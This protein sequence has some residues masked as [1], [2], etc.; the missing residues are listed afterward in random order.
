[1][2]FLQPLVSFFSRGFPL[3]LVCFRG[4]SGPV[5]RFRSGGQEGHGPPGILPPAGR[6]GGL[7]L[8]VSPRA[9]DSGGLHTSV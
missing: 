2:P 7:A 9:A 8:G 6:H 5:A 1:M 4:D 3:G